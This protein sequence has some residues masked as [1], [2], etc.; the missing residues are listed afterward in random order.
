MVPWTISRRRPELQAPVRGRLKTL[1][2]S[3]GAVV[4]GSFQDPLLWDVSSVV[5]GVTAPQAGAGAHHVCPAR[6]FEFCILVVENH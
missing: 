3:R 4:E 1:R 6:A 2:G 5:R